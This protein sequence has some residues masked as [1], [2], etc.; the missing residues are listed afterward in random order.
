MPLARITVHEGQL[1]D[2]GKR[3]MIE[4][5]TDAL[6]EGEGLGEAARASA[7]VVVEEVPAGS[8]GAGGGVVDW[9]AYRDFVRGAAA[10]QGEG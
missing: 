10:G 9:P 6:V 7:W 1:D 4:L 2:A 5:V 8:F 3:R